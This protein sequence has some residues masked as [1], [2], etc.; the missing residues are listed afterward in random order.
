[1]IRYG[2][3]AVLGHLILFTGVFLLVEIFNLPESLSYFI[4]ITFDYAIVY[5]LNLKFVF[6]SNFSA[7]NAV[8]YLVYL[9]SSWLVNNLFFI[10]MTDILNIYYIISLVINVLLFSLIKYFIQ[11]EIIFKE[12]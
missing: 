5:V 10:L 8:K 12:Q 11:K 6:K 3:V 2:L 4:I 9:F 1:M 7:G